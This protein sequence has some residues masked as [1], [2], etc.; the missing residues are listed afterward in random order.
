ML[1]Q[2]ILSNGLLPS[3]LSHKNKTNTAD[4][5]KRRETVRNT[6]EKV[7]TIDMGLK[8]SKLHSA[9]LQEDWIQTLRQLQTD[10]H[11]AMIANRYG[12]YPIHL[13]CYTGAPPYV[14]RMLINAYPDAVMMTNKAGYN[15]LDIASKNYKISNPHRKQ[16]LAMLRTYIDNHLCSKYCEET[17]TDCSLESVV[18][19]Q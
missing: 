18:M 11:N 17:D 7:D 16:V 13:A 10:K 12:D 3:N 2:D 14:I 4:T 1:W 5:I 19:S 8:H 15:P 9:I 6:I